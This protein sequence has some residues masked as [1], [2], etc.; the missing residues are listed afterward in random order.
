MRWISTMN[1]ERPL[2]MLLLVAVGAVLLSCA[3][4]YV[5]TNRW[6][7]ASS[8]LT[9]GAGGGDV[10]TIRVLQD[11][12]RRDSESRIRAG[13]TL[14]ASTAATLLAKVGDARDVVSQADAVFARWNETVPALMTSEA[15]KRL[16][17][18]PKRVET[19]HAIYT[20]LARPTERS[21][22]AI[23]D[24]LDVVQGELERLKSDEEATLSAEDAAAFEGR[25]E[26]DHAAA[27]G[28][29]RDIKHDL[30]AIESLVQASADDSPGTVTLEAALKE[31]ELEL[32]AARAALIEAEKKRVIAE[33]NDL[34]TEMEG[35]K[36]EEIRSAQRQKA[37]ALLE[38]QRMQEA[39]AADVAAREAEQRDLKTRAEDPAVQANYQPFLGLGKTQPVNKNPAYGAEHCYWAESPGLEKK[40]ASYTALKAAKALERLEVFIAFATS[41]SNDRDGAWPVL[42]SDDDKGL[43]EYRKRW[44][45][46]QDLAPL[47]IEAGKLGQ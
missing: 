1:E 43:A 35:R 15:G 4:V 28:I 20:R 5:A 46:F 42:G 8:T 3:G 10:E 31:R 16:A 32:A 41:A 17:A 36:L 37:E 11:E 27:Q 14:A 30:D 12:V 39:T 22:A 13:R 29:L 9:T 26:G 34:D 45:E 23:T 24:R 44:D 18:D 25:V 7:S 6:A 19:F 38:D 33:Q 40:P 21:L 47:W 2:K